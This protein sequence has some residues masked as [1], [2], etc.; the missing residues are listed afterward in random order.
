M[1]DSAGVIESNG[2]HLQSHPLCAPLM[3]PCYQVPG[4]FLYGEKY[5]WFP[6]SRDKPDTYRYVVS[7]PLGRKSYKEQY[8]FVYR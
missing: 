6:L 8:L 2:N 7:E 3:G 4:G 5:L 1:G